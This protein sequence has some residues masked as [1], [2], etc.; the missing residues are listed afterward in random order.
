MTGKKRYLLPRSHGRTPIVTALAAD[1][2]Q[3]GCLSDFF[4]PWTRV[5][6]S[7]CWCIV[8]CRWA[9]IPVR[10]FGM[11]CHAAKQ[12]N[13]YPR[14]GTESILRSPEVPTKP[15]YPVAGYG[16]FAS[17]PLANFKK[18]VIRQSWAPRLQTASQISSQGP[19][20][21][22]SWAA[23]HT[24][25]VVVVP[26]LFPGRSPVLHHV[27]W[28]TLGISLGFSKE[29]M[30][31]WIPTLTSILDPPTKTSF[32][33]LHRRN[34]LAHRCLVVYLFCFVL[35]DLLKKVLLLCSATVREAG[36]KHL[37]SLQQDLLSWPMGVFGLSQNGH[38]RPAD[39][40]V[41]P[42]RLRG[43]LRQ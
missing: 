28:L 31:L 33:R 21:T 6:M 13:P 40:V 17:S 15:K 25:P 5:R 19:V 1:S 39:S 3:T 38:R 24:Q 27:S 34:A 16:V 9:S 11:A 29:W 23:L 7:R 14:A 12:T 37:F 8:L 20:K 42:L 30:L 36:G 41:A 4:L 35:T 26:L 2:H 18:R 22:W 10:V 32:H 43:S